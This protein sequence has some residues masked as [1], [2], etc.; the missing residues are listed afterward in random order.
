MRICCKKLLPGVSTIVKKGP[1]PTQLPTAYVVSLVQ[2]S[3]PEHTG[4]LLS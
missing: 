2:L 1:F 4:K 3:I